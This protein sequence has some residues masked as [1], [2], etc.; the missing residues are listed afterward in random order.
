MAGPQLVVPIMNARF[1]LN[2]VNARWGS[3]YDALYGTDIISEENGAEKTGAYNPVRGNKVIAFAKQFLDESFPLLSGSHIDVQK[4]QVHENKLSISLSNGEQTELKDVDAFIGYNGEHNQTEAI[5]LK[6]N[7]LNVQLCFTENHIS[8]SDPA[9]LSDVL[10]E[11]ALTTIMDCEDSV[12]AV[13]AEDKVVAYKNW[14]GLIKKDLSETIE[15]GGNSFV[16]ND[17][18]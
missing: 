5:L 3:L 14:L 9:G 11:S 6:H 18:R 1:A 8:A 10:L 4:Y 2:A 12:A 17:A 7:R 16:R 13:D 15:K